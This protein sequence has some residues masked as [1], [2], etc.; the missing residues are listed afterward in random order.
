[1]LQIGCILLAGST[2]ALFLTAPARFTLPFVARAAAGLLGLGFLLL[3][4][5]ALF[6]ALPF[7]RT[8]LEENAARPVYDR[9][10]YA[11]CRHPGVLWFLLF[12]FFGWLWSGADLLFW[13]WL[14]FGLLNVGYIVLQDCWIF[15]RTFDNYGDYRKTTPFL[16]PTPASIRRCAGTMRA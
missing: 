5:H 10:V 1:M 13:A 7:K 12:Y 3:L 15:P 2:A 9:G 16:I 8:Y 6:F 4:V 11:L 14:L